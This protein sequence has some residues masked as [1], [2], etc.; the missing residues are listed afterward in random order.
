[1]LERGSPALHQC[2]LTQQVDVVESAMWQQCYWLKRHVLRRRLTL[3]NIAHF[4]SFTTPTCHLRCVSGGDELQPPMPPLYIH[5]RHQCPRKAH[6]SWLERHVK[7]P[8]DTYAT[9]CIIPSRRYPSGI[10]LSLYRLPFLQQRQ[11]DVQS[12]KNLTMHR[13]W[14]GCYILIECWLVGANSHTN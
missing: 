12:F 14:Q 6:K 13:L 2:V 10:P 7:R 1:M 4:A 11:T 3:I 9:G 8:F 5:R